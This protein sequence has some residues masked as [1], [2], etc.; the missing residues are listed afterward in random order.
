MADLK[1]DSKTYEYNDLEKKYANFIWPA[2]EVSVDGRNLVQEEV[3]IDSVTVDTSADSK[4]D[5]FS[6]VVAN[7]FDRGKQ[8][9]LY[10]DQYFSLGKHVEIKMGYGEKV[11]TVFYGMITSV[12][13]DLPDDGSSRIIVKGMDMSFLMMKGKHSAFWKEKKHSEVAREIGSKYVSQ[14]KVDDTTEVHNL[15]VQNEQEDFHF[16]SWLAE[17]NDYDFFVVGKTMYFRK[18]S[19][20]TS[21]VLTL[22]WGKSLHAFSLDANLTSQISS[23]VVRGWNEKEFTHIEAESQSVTKL[24]SNS[25]TGPDLIKALGEAKEYVYNDVVSAAEAQQQANAILNKRA[26]QLLT[27][28]GETVGIPELRAGRYVKLAGLGNKLSQPFYLTSVTH[29]IDDSGYLTRFRVGGNAI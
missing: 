18:R 3:P 15:V 1:L 5:A 29:T 16:L 23:V 20:D 8:E 24:G 25:K 27:G 9:F 22:E 2:F 26:M 11:E 7:A 28:E 13:F 4:A 21:P 10:V 12:T 14:V 6:F 19:S 17:A